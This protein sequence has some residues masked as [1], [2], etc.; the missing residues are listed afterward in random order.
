MKPNLT[1]LFGFFWLV[2][3][4]LALIVSAAGAYS[5]CMQV[6]EFAWGCDPFGYLRMAKEV[7]KARDEGHYPD[8]RMETPQSRVLM[9]YMLSHDVPAESWSEM[10]APH[11]HHYFPR[12]NQVGVQ[13]PPGTGLF[14]AMF[15][16][17]EAVHGMCRTVI[18]IFVGVGLLTL[19]VAGITRAWAAAGGVVFA[20]QFGLEIL[21]GLG[22]VSFSVNAVLAPLLIA[23]TLLFLSLI[24]RFAAD[25]P[26]MAAVV[27]LLAGTSFGFAVLVRLPVLFLL[28]GAAILL[29]GATRRTFFNSALIGFGLGFALGGVLP[30][31]HHQQQITGAW[32][33][34]TYGL[35]DSSPPSREVVEKNIEFYFKDGPGSKYNWPVRISLVGFLALAFV[36]SRAGEILSTIGWV[37]ILLAAAVIGFLS[38]AYF[39]THRI[40]ILYYQIP[41][42]FAVVVILALGGFSLQALRRQTHECDEV[43]TGSISRAVLRWFALTVALLPGVVALDAAWPLRPRVPLSAKINARQVEFPARTYRPSHMDVR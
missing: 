5:R 10:V 36:P 3:L 29:L 38:T 43:P 17:G 40:A 18:V 34:S 32:Y 7:R 37:R 9:D 19:V 23:F 28:P 16:Q 11:A 2:A 24:L 4:G 12:S 35:D 22:A 6:E 33:L 15:P 25:W 26:R 1:G 31:L 30:L 20:L 42:I 41:A 27:A 8:Y 13:Y 21:G 14:L 39:L